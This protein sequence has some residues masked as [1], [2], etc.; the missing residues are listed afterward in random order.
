MEV[1]I[2]ENQ[3]RYV[4]PSNGY[5]SCLG[6]ENAERQARTRL[7]WLRD[8][9]PIEAWAIAPHGLEPLGTIELYNQLQAINS[10]IHAIHL[11]TG[12]KCLVDLSPQLTGKERQ[13]VSVVDEFGETR[14]FTVGRS[15]GYIPVHLELKS[16]RSS[17]GEAASRVYRSVHLV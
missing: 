16:R 9:A 8:R 3:R 15:G 17:S 2:N 6:F 10:A 5:V 11:R 7:E 13:R 12:E 1:T 4:I 14:R